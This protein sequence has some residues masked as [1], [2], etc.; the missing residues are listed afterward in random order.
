M[1]ARLSA[2][3]GFAKLIETEAV[4][5]WDY[6]DEET[7]LRGLFSFGAAIRAVDCAGE[8]RVRE[9]TLKFLAPY[10]LARGGYRLENSFRYL[11]AQ[12]A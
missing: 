4:S 12:R 9:V 2:R 10:R 3:A 8:A 1:M 6:A 5:I 11:I 7:A